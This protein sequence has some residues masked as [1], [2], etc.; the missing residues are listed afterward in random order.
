MGKDFEPLFCILPIS[1]ITL[2]NCKAA[3]HPKLIKDVLNLSILF[4]AVIKGEV[5][6]NIVFLQVIRVLCE[7]IT[8][9]LWNNCFLHL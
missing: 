1:L 6:R 5:N 8:E 7:V 9:M 2:N 3:F 4:T